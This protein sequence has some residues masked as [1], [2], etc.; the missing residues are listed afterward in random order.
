MKIKKIT[1]KKFFLT[2]S[3]AFLLGTIVSLYSYGLNSNKISNNTIKTIKNYTN[4]QTN[5]LALPQLNDL[6]NDYSYNKGFIKI[7]DNSKIN[8]YN[9]FGLKAWDYDVISNWNSIFGNFPSATIDTLK[10]KSDFENSLIYVYG[11]LNND[12]YTSFV[13]RLNVYGLLV[14]FGTHNAFFS[15]ENVSWDK[16]LI[17][18]V[19]LLTVTKSGYIILTQKIPV[20]ILINNS[21][22]YLLNISEIDKQSNSI[23]SKQIDITSM[24]NTEDRAPYEISVIG[25]IIY[26]QKLNNQYTFGIKVENTW[27]DNN[28][29][30][31]KGKKRVA[32]KTILIENDAYSQNSNNNKIY[33][34]HYWKSG[35]INLDEA[36]FNVQDISTSANEQKI[37]VSMKY[38]TTSLTITPNS[39]PTYIGETVLTSSTYNTNNS[40]VVTAGHK[41]NVGNSSGDIAGIIGFLYDYNTQQPY[42]VLAHRTLTSSFAIAPLTSSISNAAGWINFESLLQTGLHQQISI[43]F[44][45]GSNKDNKFYGFLE[46]KKQ[47]YSVIKTINS[48]TITLFALD[49]SLTSLSNKNNINLS[50]SVS[51]DEISSK[52]SKGDYYANEQTKKEI[53]ADLTKVE[54]NGL[55]YP[56]QISSE[57]LII[58]TQN[59]SIKGQVTFYINNW[60]NSDITEITRN[61]NL[62]FDYY[63]KPSDTAIPNSAMISANVIVY[64]STVLFVLMAIASALI[65]FKVIQTRKNRKLKMNN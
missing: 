5:S 2:T 60:W 56:T 17:K 4:V 34:F 26:A 1:L 38:D 41:N 47:N 32:V 52:Y 18:G 30:E 12:D 58:D 54:Q 33:S 29:K 53:I 23:I 24:E 8:F 22:K 50:L 21:I 16:R 36:I 61:V 51:D 6:Y 59:N 7:T 40:L 64:S 3:T 15:N 35:N 57:N 14:P 31:K 44:I 65:I 19:N 27:T 55:N 62:I 9:W 42:V 25:E 45:P 13:F 43:G 39:N 48:E 28:D 20:K 63:L 46:I 49:S 11:I 37:I 10:V